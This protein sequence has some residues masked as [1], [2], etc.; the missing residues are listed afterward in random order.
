LAGK[1]HIAH[2]LFVDTG[3]LRC[4]EHVDTPS[5]ALAQMKKPAV[6]GQGIL[7][8][9]TAAWGY[10]ARASARAP[11]AHCLVHGDGL[12]AG[13]TAQHGSRAAMDAAA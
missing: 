8:E 11:A 13:L 3:N 10:R 7:G 4:H 6:C 1:T 9:A 5:P 2:I 12:Q